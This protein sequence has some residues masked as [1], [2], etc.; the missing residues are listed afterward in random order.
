MVSTLTLQRLIGMT[1]K[2]YGRRR[3]I[4]G[5]DDIIMNGPVFGGDT[6]YADSE[7]V[8]LDPADTIR[9]VVHG[10]KADGSEVARITC[11]MAMQR[12]DAA[13]RTSRRGTLRRLPFCG[14]RRFGRANRPVVRG[15]RV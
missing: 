9:V 15:L 6:L 12:R 14:R 8:G 5:F 2:T 13:Q 7:V 11:R 4:L 3:A 10:L 1:S